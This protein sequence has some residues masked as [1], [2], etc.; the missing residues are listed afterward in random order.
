MGIREVYGGPSLSFALEGSRVLQ[1]EY[2]IMQNQETAALLPCMRYRQ[3]GA[4]ALCYLTRGQ[5]RF[6]DVIRNASGRVFLAAAADLF[7]NIA[8]LQENGFLSCRKLDIRFHRIY[9]DAKTNRTRLL[10]IPADLYLFPSEIEF[11]RALR[12]GFIRF[13]TE[14]DRNAGDFLR[15]LRDRTLSVPEIGERLLQRAGDGR[16]TGGGTS[17]GDPGPEA[18]LTAVN[19]SAPLVFMSAGISIPSG[20]GDRPQTA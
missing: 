7:L 19:S 14:P 13:L 1:T 8:R 10:Y 18:I 20:G 6:A 5:K 17:C 3:N 11:D 16:E 12:D 4:E 15:D 9:V 2:K